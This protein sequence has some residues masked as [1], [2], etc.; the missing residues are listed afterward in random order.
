MYERER[1]RG[2]LT[3]KCSHHKSTGARRGGPEDRIGQ[4]RTLR[5]VSIAVATVQDLK[6]ILE[7][8]ADA[9]LSALETDVVV[10]FLVD[11]ARQTL[12]GAAG[13]TSLGPEGL[14]TLEEAY[15]GTLT[16]LEFPLQR[17]NTLI[18]DTMLD[19]KPRLGLSPRRLKEMTRY[20]EIIPLLDT[21]EAAFGEITVSMVPLVARQ[22]RVGVMIFLNPEQIHPLD[23]ELIH[24]FASLAAVSIENARVYQNLKTLNQQIIETLVAAIEIRDPYTSGHCFKVTQWAI[25]IAEEMELAGEEIEN[26]QLVGPLHDL[27][28]IAIPDGILNKP[29]TLNDA[30]RALVAT[31]PVIGANLVAKIDALAHLVP[32]IRHHHERY[33]GRG[34][35]DEL[36]G[37]DIPSF[38][39]ILAVADG[40]EAMTAERPYR[41]AKSQEEA[42]EE[43]KT[44]AGTQWDPEVVEVFLEVL[45]KEKS[46]V[47]KKPSV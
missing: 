28:K 32:I 42:V 25:A 35:P 4:F 7:K 20:K 23:K 12:V 39:R 43:L 38:A 17:G 33:D 26:L 27:G 44:G 18:V 31:H 45:G 37:E 19:G 47:S 34:Y 22:K 24:A 46:T 8:I 29:S 21:A 2:S 11:E 13:S 3:L 30:E 6:E 1:E 40:F 41:F 15:G 5:E 10:I 16:E 14:G 9:A 36:K